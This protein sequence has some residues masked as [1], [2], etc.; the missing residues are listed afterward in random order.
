M[1]TGLYSSSNLDSLDLLVTNYTEEYVALI[2]RTVAGQFHRLIDSYLALAD[3]YSILRRLA[4]TED[5]HVAI[6]SPLMLLDRSALQG[7]G[8]NEQQLEKID[9][10]LSWVRRKTNSD[11][12]TLIKSRVNWL[13]RRAA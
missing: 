13:E 10:F 11:F 1:R 5:A 6:P 2:E 8:Y 4:L 12:A 3:L 7:F 9:R